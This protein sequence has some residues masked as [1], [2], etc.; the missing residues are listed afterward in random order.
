MS[1]ETLD[2]FEMRIQ[3]NLDKLET[4]RDDEVRAKLIREV[5]DL[6]G[7]M[8]AAEELV[9]RYAN[10]EEQRKLDDVK[11]QRAL[12]AEVRK[13]S[14][15]WKKA[16]VEIGKVVIPAAVSLVSISLFNEKF[17]QVL[18]FEE[19]GRFTSTAFRLLRWPKVM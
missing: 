1:N 16:A 9:Y 17:E 14:L 4:E 7:S 5:K 19:S 6:S 15:D 18:K 2:M 8:T 11:S 3:E 13:A 10:D 12:E